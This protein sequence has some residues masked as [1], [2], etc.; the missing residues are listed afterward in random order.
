MSENAYRVRRALTDAEIALIT[1]AVDAARNAA[2]IIDAA[3]RVLFTA[4][5]TTLGE[6]LD[7]Y[8]PDQRLDP[9]AFAIPQAQSD[10]IQR[11][12]LAKADAF[13]ASAHIVFEL[14]NLMPATYDDP[15]VTAPAIP[16]RDQRP[17]AH[18][19]TV[20]REATDVIAAASQ[21]CRQIAA[22][23]GEDSREHLEAVGSWQ[24]SISRVFSMVFGA[25]T[26]ITRDGDLSLLV[27]CGSGFTYAIIFHPRQRTCL[28]DGCAAVIND[29]GTAWTYRRDDP[30]CPDGEH[31]L[32]YPLDAP[33][34]GSW[35][36][37][38]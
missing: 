35:S 6:S 7:D 29:D 2:E 1:A 8:G 30:T 20:S 25:E 18:S 19:V 16:I 10:A 12:C 11:V 38:S 37:H 26:H 4:L 36:F 5:L 28:N 34:L 9:G 31:A 23:F 15:T 33:C 14:I 24:D 3:L 21:H 32:S 27:Q 13:G 22:F 17:Y